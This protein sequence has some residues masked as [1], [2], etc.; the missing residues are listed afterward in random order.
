MGFGNSKKKEIE[1]PTPPDKNE[2]KTIFQICSNKLTLFR[3]K[4]IN[5][6]C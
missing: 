5:I 3:N 6:I 1:V 4:K 2:L